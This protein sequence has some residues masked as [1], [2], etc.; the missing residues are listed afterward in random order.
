MYKDMNSK[1][2]NNFGATW[3]PN[4]FSS[5]LHNVRTDHEETKKLRSQAY[6][7]LQ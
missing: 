3:Q 1:L 6:A 5:S 7:K 4:Q 2:N